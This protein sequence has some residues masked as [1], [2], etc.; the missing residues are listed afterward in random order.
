MLLQL[1]DAA[2]E[3]EVEWPGLDHP[4][5]CV[6]CHIDSGATINPDRL[7]KACSAMECYTVFDIRTTPAEQLHVIAR[8]HADTPEQR[9]MLFDAS[10]EMSPFLNKRFIASIHERNRWCLFIA[11]DNHDDALFF[12]VT[13]KGSI[14]ARSQIERSLLSFVHAQHRLQ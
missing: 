12:S 7:L 1:V 8:G 10:I 3:L 5:P 6:Y 13:A 11:L 4:M 9:T 14:L 2:V